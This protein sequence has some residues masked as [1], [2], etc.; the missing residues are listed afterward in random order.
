MEAHAVPLLAIFEK[1]HRLEVP[2][3]QRQ[4]V[5]GLNNQWAPLWEDISRKFTEYLEGRR[6]APVHFLGA[7]VLDQ[8][9][10]PTTYVERR[11]IIDG[12][13]RLTTLQ[14]FIAAFRDFC[15]SKG[16]QDLANEC[17]SFTINKGMMS[18]PETEKYK[19]WPTQRDRQFFTDAIDSGSIEEITNRYPLRRRKYA[20][21]P[22]PRP[23]I[24]EAYLYFHKE[25][26]TFFIGTD[27]E[28]PLANHKELYVRLEESFQALKNVLKVVV[29][30]LEQDDDA[31]VIFETL[32]ARGEPLLPA[33]LLRNYIFL[34]ATRNRE[35]PE[36]LYQKYWQPFDDQFWRQ[37]IKQG[38]L[39]R[40]RS[41]LFMQ[42]FL[43]SK[44][45]EDIPIKHLFVEY[46]YWIQN[47]TP[48]PSVESELRDLAHLGSAFRRIIEPKRDDHLFGFLTFL[49]VFDI[50]TVYPLLLLFLEL[51]L[52]VDQWKEITTC[53]ESYLLRRAVCGF[54]TKNYNR[55]F[56]SLTKNIRSKGYS[57]SALST[58]L[59]AL[60]GESSEWPSDETFRQAWETKNAYEM[61]QGSRIV[62]ILKAISDTY[63]DRRTE[64][65]TIDSPSTV[66]HLLPRNWLENWPLQNGQKGL[67][68]PDLFDRPADDP[69][70]IA[71]KQRNAALNTFGNLTIL[72]GPLNSSVS[73]S[74]WQ[75]KKPE[76]M[77]ASLLPINQVLHQYDTWDENAILHRSKVLFERAMRLWPGSSP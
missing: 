49:A 68:W 31:Q 46:K 10:T 29:I 12:Q 38:R 33:D 70:A 28:P 60:R 61:I 3:F 42:H 56:L 41:D 40:P 59:S 74:S 67:A 65:I 34:R 44:Q 25:I 14:L 64:T 57:K 72:S 35:D 1:K 4:Y 37:E 48:Y 58:H 54:P 15:R 13:Q 66:E 27:D 47:K 7:I 19:V 75:V 30:D 52:D 20:R 24:I 32:N 23:R 77:N 6:D 53:L 17:E 51:N 5:W 45:C 63:M 43:A 39:F 2:L 9:F 16:F 22:D 69:I 62:Y 36:F 8:K 26:G 18:S 21:L 50:G 11:Q 71:T 73:N 55:I 76:L